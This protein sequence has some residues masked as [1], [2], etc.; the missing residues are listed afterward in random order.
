MT[1]KKQTAAN[2]ANAQKS[3]GPK[4]AAG[5]ARSAQN[6]VKHGVT[7]RPDWSMVTRFYRMIVEDSTALPDPFSS[8]PRSRAALALAEAEASFRRAAEAERR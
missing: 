6:A 3:S 7:G 1:T 2:K 5:K 4:S 8:D